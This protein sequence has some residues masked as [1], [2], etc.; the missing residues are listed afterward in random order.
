M[1]AS[2][3]RRS[4]PALAAR[5][6][7]QPLARACRSRARVPPVAPLR[8]CGARDR[9]PARPQVDGR[10]GAHATQPRLCARRTV[11]RGAGF[12]AAAAAAGAAQCADLRPG[13]RRLHHRQGA[14]RARR[15]ATAGHRAGGR[16]RCALARRRRCALKPAPPAR[17]ALH[18][19]AA[20][21]VRAACRLSR[22]AA[23]LLQRSSCARAARPRPP[24]AR[25]ELTAAC[26]LVRRWSF[27]RQPDTID[28][29]LMARSTRRS[30]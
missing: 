28:E 2:H 8:G 15:L 4:S 21:H 20:R 13:E 12:A 9:G 19:R 25:P 30:S 14:R 5:S 6:N 7:A 16:S 18:A 24:L 23:A 22:P 11:L 27:S 29:R 1:G 10:G 3:L 26:T 17:A